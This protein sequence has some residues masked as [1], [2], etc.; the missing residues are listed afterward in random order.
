MTGRISISNNLEIAIRKTLDDV[1]KLRKI[2]HQRAAAK[3]APRQS[4]APDAWEACR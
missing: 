1:A 2:G 4:G 3:R